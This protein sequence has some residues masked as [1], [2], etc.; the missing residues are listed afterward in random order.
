MT[1]KSYVPNFWMSFSNFGS[2][3]NNF[4]CHSVFIPEYLGDWNRKE[5]QKLQI[6]AHEGG[7]LMA[8]CIRRFF[9]NRKCKSTHN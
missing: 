8:S 3:L 5:I 9:S 1:K 2:S 6:H 4:L 7:L